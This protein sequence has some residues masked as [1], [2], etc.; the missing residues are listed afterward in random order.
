L[1]LFIGFT[2]HLLMPTPLLFYWCKMDRVDRIT[3]VDLMPTTVK[4]LWGG[5]TLYA[6]LDILQR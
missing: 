2:T 4:H 5:G 6:G 3:G 1:S